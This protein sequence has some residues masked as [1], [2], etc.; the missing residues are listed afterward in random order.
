MFVIVG[1]AKIF[2]GDASNSIVPATIK[3][4]LAYPHHLL[5]SI[6][7]KPQEIIVQ[8]QVHE[9]TGLIVDQ[10]TINVYRKSLTHNSDFLITSLLNVGIGVFT[11]DCLSLVLHDPVNNVVGIAH[12]GWKGSVGGIVK[13]ML[14]T[15]VQLYGCNTA[16]IIA[17][18]GPS[19]RA[20][21][22][23]VQPDFAENLK[24]FAWANQTLVQRENKLCF[25]NLLFNCLL[26][27]E[28][29]MTEK[30]LITTHAHCTI[31][32]EQYCSF[33]RSGGMLDRQ[34]SVVWL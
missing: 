6:E 16:N 9:N 34:I 11:A 3:E 31:C 17:I 26:L 7:Q 5:G 2:F 29:G 18:A 12:A 28:C 14:T 15:M 22:Y 13:Q 32:N 30:Q 4:Q 27:Q 8:H 21:C 20:C 24:S 23:E 25:D 19:A 1:N 10:C 33:R